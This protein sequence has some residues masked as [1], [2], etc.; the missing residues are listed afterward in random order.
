[1]AWSVC[2]VVAV[3][4]NEDILT[5]HV[6]SEVCQEYN[7]GSQVRCLAWDPTGKLLAMGTETGDIRVGF[8]H[9]FPHRV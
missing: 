5:M 1:M 6:G 2:D 3:A 8:D 9:K 4:D 7:A